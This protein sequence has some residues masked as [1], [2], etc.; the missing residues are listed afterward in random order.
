MLKESLVCGGGG[1]FV[2]GS[3]GVQEG[4]RKNPVELISFIK[5]VALILIWVDILIKRSQCSQSVFQGGK[6]GGA[7]LKWWSG[8]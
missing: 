8:F 5:R 7:K 4:K 3:L 6:G 2:A 1:S